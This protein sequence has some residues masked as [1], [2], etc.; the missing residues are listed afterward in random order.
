MAQ[1]MARAARFADAAVVLGVEPSGQFSVYAG[2]GGDTI[3]GEE[4]GDDLHGG[5]A[6]EDGFG[7]VE[8]AGDAAGGSQR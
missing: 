8:A 3:A 5:R 7:R 1:P 2:Q 4:G 6:A